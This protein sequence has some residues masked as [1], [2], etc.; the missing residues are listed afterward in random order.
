MRAVLVPLGIETTDFGT[1]HGDG[2][3]VIHAAIWRCVIGEFTGCI[4]YYGDDYGGG[5]YTVE[6]D[7]SWIATGGDVGI[8]VPE[9]VE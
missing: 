6:L 8:A 3:I 1:F 7:P 2:G 9:P 4:V 5:R